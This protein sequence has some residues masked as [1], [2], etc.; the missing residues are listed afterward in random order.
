MAKLTKQEAAGHAQACALLQKEVLTFDD[1][2]SVLDN[3][4]AFESTLSRIRH[5]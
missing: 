4:S 3:P 2:L 1:K 5:L